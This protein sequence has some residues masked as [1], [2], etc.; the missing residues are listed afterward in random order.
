M[1]I[2]TASLP[3]KIK[4]IKLNKGMLHEVLTAQLSNKRAATASTKTRGEVSGGGKKP[5]R[6]KGTGR[7]RVGSN[8]SPLWKGGGITFGPTGEQSFKK[9]ISKKKKKAAIIQAFAQRI[10]EENVTVV[11]KLE[12]AEIKTRLANDFLT[13]ALGVS[14][15]K[16]LILYD[17]SSYETIRAFRNIKN[18]TALDWR[19]LNVYDIINNEKILLDESTWENI[20]TA[21]GL[22]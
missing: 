8:R 3:E 12:L 2:K 10:K 17:E 11:D 4:D 15:V 6:Q 21:K 14:G 16:T 19:H 9:K 22:K 18:T 1:N 7:A 5:W 13:E 20:L